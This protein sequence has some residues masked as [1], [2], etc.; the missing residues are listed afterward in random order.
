MVDAHRSRDIVM[1]STSKDSDL[2]SEELQR[3][4]TAAP[5]NTA[6]HRVQ[7]TEFVSQ[8]VQH[9]TNE[10]EGQTRDFRSHDPASGSPEATDAGARANE[11]EDQDTPIDESRDDISID[12]TEIRMQRNEQ[13]YDFRDPQRYIMTAEYRDQ[14]AK[15]A[16]VAAIYTEGLEN[17][18]S[19]LERELLELQ[20]EFGSKA[21]PDIIKERRVICSVLNP[22]Q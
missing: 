8:P 5:L 10:G 21:R 11:K 12:S 7:A 19:G 13:P 20:Y 16:R 4:A 2:A 17:R 18:V 3:N 9:E 22:K 14:G 1:A 15:F 6:P